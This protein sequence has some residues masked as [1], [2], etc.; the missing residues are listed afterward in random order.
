MR[1]IVHN[2]VLLFRTA[3]INTA[4]KYYCAILVLKFETVVAANVTSVCICMSTWQPAIYSVTTA[5]NKQRDI[6]TDRGQTNKETFCILFAELCALQREATVT[7]IPLHLHLLMQYSMH[8]Y[9]CIADLEK[10]VKRLQAEHADTI[11][12]LEKTRN[13]LIIQH[14]IN[15]DYQAEVR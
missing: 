1:L 7:N 2:P 10:V 6:L 13:M 9:A 14:K 5:T 11:T 4:K 12:E 3:C 8:L 15:K